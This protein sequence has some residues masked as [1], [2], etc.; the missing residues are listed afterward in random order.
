[1]ND[2]MG[3]KLIPSNQY[4]G[5]VSHVSGKNEW[6]WSGRLDRNPKITMVAR[7][8]RNTRNVWWYEENVF[9]NWRPDVSIQY[10]CQENGEGD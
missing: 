2:L 6:S 10:A 4:T 3:R 8:F 9:D 1:M 5:T 7:I